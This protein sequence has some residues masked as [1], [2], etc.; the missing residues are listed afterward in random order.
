[1]RGPLLAILLLL[2]APGLFFAFRLGLLRNR[3]TRWTAAVV[4]V[5][6][7]AWSLPAA[8]VDYLYLKRIN[9]FLCAAAATLAL[10]RN[11]R[12][13]WVMS[14]RRHLAA[15]AGGAAAPPAP[16]LDL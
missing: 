5:A 9:L 7:L 8:G 6:A 13:A 15:L 2:V 11:P 10:L 4:A 16:L 14:P 12:L 1:M 3:W